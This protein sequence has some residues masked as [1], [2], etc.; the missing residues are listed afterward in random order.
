[1][2]NLRRVQRTQM[3][4]SGRIV[5]ADSSATIDCIVCDLTNLGAG[6]RVSPGD[7]V[8][9]F[10]E[11]IFDSRLFSRSCQVRWKHN[12]RLGVEFTPAQ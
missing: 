12:E 8:P 4:K 9:D 2:Q 5:T 7:Y 10:F 1:M 11:L 6:L 3:I